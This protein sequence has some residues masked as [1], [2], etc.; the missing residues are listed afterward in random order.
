MELVGWWGFDYRLFYAEPCPTTVS[1]R[2]CLPTGGCNSPHVAEHN[3]CTVPAWFST[4][5]QDVS[6]IHG[7]RR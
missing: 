3:N 4:F 1:T 5:P 7:V 6:A 2:S